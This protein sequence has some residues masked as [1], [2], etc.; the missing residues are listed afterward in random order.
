MIACVDAPSQGFVALRHSGFVQEPGIF[1]CLSGC[2]HASC[3]VSVFSLHVSDVAE[4]SLT[5]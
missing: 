3:T 2:M 4:A 1:R 5:Q